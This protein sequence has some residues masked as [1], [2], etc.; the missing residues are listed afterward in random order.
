MRGK[1]RRKRTGTGIGRD[2]VL[3]IHAGIDIH[4]LVQLYYVHLEAKPGPDMVGGDC[5]V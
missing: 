2:R 5:I 3:G 1:Q 4:C